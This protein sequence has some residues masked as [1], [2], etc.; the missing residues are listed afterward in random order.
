MWLPVCQCFFFVGLIFTLWQQF[1]WEF[2]SCKFGTH[3]QKFGKNHQT[4]ETTK[5]GGGEGKKP[6]VGGEHCI[7]CIFVNLNSIS[8]FLE[9]EFH[10]N[11]SLL[12]SFICFPLDLILVHQMSTIF[13]FF[14]FLLGSY[15][16]FKWTH[17]TFS[18][19]IIS[20]G[21]K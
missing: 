9:P 5:L 7:L 13:S 4:F 11:Y 1:F 16:I 10:P 3:C 14:H 18:L 19:V 2:V 17:T 12:E 20:L 6:C 15:S 8:P 21:F